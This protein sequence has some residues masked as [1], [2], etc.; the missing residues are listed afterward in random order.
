MGE[1]AGACSVSLHLLSP[2]SRHL[3]SQANIK[4]MIQQ[5]GKHHTTKQQSCKYSPGNHAVC[6][7]NCTLG[8]H[9]QGGVA[10]P[11]TQV[12]LCLC[13]CDTLSLWTQVTLCLCQVTA[14]STKGIACRLA[15]LMDCPHDRKNIRGAIECLRKANATDMVGNHF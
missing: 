13:L 7:S 11:W 1:S 10:A 6:F 14:F 12:T 15:E 8:C 2:L 9:H 4:L 5:S 3:F